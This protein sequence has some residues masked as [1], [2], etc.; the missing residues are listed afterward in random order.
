[1]AAPTVLA[2]SW[3]FGENVWSVMREKGQVKRKTHTDVTNTR[4]AIIEPPS[5]KRLLGLVFVLSTTTYMVRVILRIRIE[6][7]EPTSSIRLTVW[8][9]FST[10]LSSKSLTCGWISSRSSQWQ[11]P[12]AERDIC[13]RQL[14]TAKNNV[15]SG[16]LQIRKKMQ[17]N[18]S[19]G[20]SS[21]SKSTDIHQNQPS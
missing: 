1:M 15:V 10:P 6:T 14:S 3:C 18:N 9:A 13:C 2:T 11:C 21:V 16:D 12:R 19:K 7:E 5:T 4:G 20:G 17:V 8:P